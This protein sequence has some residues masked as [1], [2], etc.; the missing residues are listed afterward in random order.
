M[1]IPRPRRALGVDIDAAAD[2]VAA[3]QRAK[4]RH[5]RIDFALPGSG[6]RRALL[7]AV[8]NQRSLQYAARDGAELARPI[9]V[10]RVG[11]VPEPLPVGTVDGVIDRI[12]VGGNSVERDDEIE[13]EIDEG[14][15]H[16]L[17]SQA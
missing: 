15:Q 5:A 10:V 2:C 16:R 7:A 9:L 17:R 8:V 12:G 14:A 11:A 1:T 3:R 6:P 4:R 13:D